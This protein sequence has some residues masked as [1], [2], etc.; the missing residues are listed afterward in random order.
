MIDQPFF[1]F[2]RKRIMWDQ[3]DSKNTNKDVGVVT[4]I[5]L[6][7]LRYLKSYININIFFLYDP[8]LVAIEK[9]ISGINKAVNIKT[10][11]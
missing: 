9:W 10:N 5:S 4:I 3:K 11:M 6:L 7:L 8:F 2:N 1:G